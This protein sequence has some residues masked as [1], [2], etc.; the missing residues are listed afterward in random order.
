MGNLST[1]DIE[2]LPNGEGKVILGD[3]EMTITKTKG[4]GINLRINIVVLMCGKG[5]ILNGSTI[6]LDDY[7]K[8]NHV[9][10]YD[11]LKCLKKIEGEYESES[12]INKKSIKDAVRGLNKRSKIELDNSLFEIKN[13]GL[14]WILK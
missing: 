2:L 9:E 13:D 1:A 11:L 12:K 10:F 6:S 4:S 7:E 8:G 14:I 3:K 5:I